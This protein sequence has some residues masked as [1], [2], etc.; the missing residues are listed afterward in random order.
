M[1]KL[2][3]TYVKSAIGYNQDQKRTL[4]ALGLK[5][6]HHSVEL[7]DTPSIRGMV[8][9]VEHLVSLEEVEG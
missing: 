3:V 9:K 8:F 5:K 4:Q 7:P 6:L 1:G 2:R